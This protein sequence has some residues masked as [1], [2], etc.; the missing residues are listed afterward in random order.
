MERVGEKYSGRGVEFIPVYVR[1][2]HAGETGFRQYRKHE[3]FE[4]KMSYARELIDIKGLSM[5][6]AVDGMDEAVHAILG[7]L[8]NVVYVV[9]KTGTIVFKAPWLDAAEVDR[10][11]AELVTKDD[12]ARPIEPSITTKDLG[13]EI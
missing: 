2:P 10:V 5:P 13:P 6:V 12:P 3:D 4:H 8:P 7:D 9:D 1:E 11:L